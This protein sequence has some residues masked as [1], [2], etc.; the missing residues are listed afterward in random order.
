MRERTTSGQARLEMV[1]GSMFAG[2]TGELIRR[3]DRDSRAGYR[4]EVFKPA[5]DDRWGLAEEICSHDGNKLPAVAIPPEN[6]SK[7]LDVLDPDTNVV[8]FEEIQFFSPEIIKVIGALQDAGVRVIGA[9]LPSDFRNEPF[10]SVPQL[11]AKADAIT[12][13]TAVCTHDN[14]GEICGLEATRTQRFLNGQPAHWDDPV[15]MI[16]ASEMYS[17]RCSEHHEVQGKKKLY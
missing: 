12:R 7:V 2:K 5:N 11:L 8:L 4:V 17:A 10:G 13:L 9:G 3:A 1:V 14:R 16:G 6:P 15:I